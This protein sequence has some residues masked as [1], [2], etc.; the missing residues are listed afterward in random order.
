MSNKKN[1]LNE[2]Q[3]RQFMKL[4]SLHPLTPGFVNG[5]TEKVEEDLEEGTE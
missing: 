4:A 1:L 3:V 2:A 5:L